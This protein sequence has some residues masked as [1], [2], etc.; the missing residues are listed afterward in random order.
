[1]DFLIPVVF[2]IVGCLIGAVILF[3]RMH[4]Q[5]E[6][7]KN[8]MDETERLLTAKLSESD[9]E[10]GILD[11]R[12]NRLTAEKARVESLL[13]AAN[14]QIKQLE[15][16]H[17]DLKKDQEFLI[18]RKKELEDLH[19]K[20]TKEFQSLSDSILK[21]QSREFSELNR[22]NLTDLLTPLKE[23]IR[24]FEKRVEETHVKGS[25]NIASLKMQL[26]MLHDLNK[27]IS[28]EAKN[29]T[30]ALKTDTK[31][32]GNWGELVLEKVLES[33]GLTK[34]IEY[35]VQMS[36][37]TDEGDRFRP[38]VIV[39][40]PEK[41]HIVI[42]SKVSLT[43]YHSYIS[44]ADDSERDKYLRQHLLSVRNHLRELGDKK[45]YDLSGINAPDFVLMFMAIESSFSLALQH[46]SSIFS[47]AWAKRIVIV[48]PTTLLAT[49]RTVASIWMHEKQT[50]N[51]LRIAEQGGK[52]YDKFV[53]FLQNLDSIGKKL[54]DAKLAFNETVSGLST[55]K[56]N[57]VSRVEKLKELGAKVSKAIP[58]KYTGS[59]QLESGNELEEDEKER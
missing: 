29:L 7:T 46:D 6:T 48:S 42:D 56:G 10:K 17:A 3:F 51:A 14:Q 30:L 45:Y 18:E 37:T 35:E 16:T 54:D 26:Q 12:L 23:K 34:G 39:N 31:K 47:D 57:L 22:K 8:Q 25:E 36:A 15:L 24:D 32:Q 28:E 13:D 50:Q 49:L 1:M 52:L 4:H 58:E 38:D 44:A 9:K 59:A 5:A 11:D 55:G 21:N 41:K 53:L 43:A 40:L 20:F 33:S 19:Q 2:F 27:Q